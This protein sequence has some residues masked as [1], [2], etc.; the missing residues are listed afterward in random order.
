MIKSLEEQD[1]SPK[2]SMFAKRVFNVSQF[3]SPLDIIYSMESIRDVIV[4][5]QTPFVF[6]DEFDVYRGEQPLGWLSHFLMPM[7]DGLF[8]TRRP[9]GRSL[10]FFAGSHYTSMRQFRDVAFPRGKSMTA[11]ESNESGHLFQDSETP[12]H[13]REHATPESHALSKAPDFLSRLKGYVDI[14]GINQDPSQ[15]GGTDTHYLRRAVLLNGL[16]KRYPRLLQR[17]AVEEDL[18]RAF[19]TVND[20]YHG[21]R[22]MEAIIEMSALSG[23]PRFTRSSLPARHL[24]DL[25]VDAQD[26][27]EKL[28]SGSVSS[29]S[30]ADAS[31]RRQAAGARPHDEVSGQT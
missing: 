20:Y 23:K 22:S 16:L 7:Q 26:F 21:S 1:I 17:G 13:L 28:T 6:W 27:I 4:R 11:P 19:L 14:V 9:I 3:D 5:G 10:F 25:H 31:M 15:R 12:E 18:I 29:T 8:G 24:M 30:E 2:D